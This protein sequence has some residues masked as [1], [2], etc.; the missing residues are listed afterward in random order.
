MRKTIYAVT[1]AAVVFTAAPAHAN[2]K[3]KDGQVACPC[4]AGACGSM[5]WARTWTAPA[6]ACAP[7]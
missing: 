3:A 4:T 6:P 5:R 2:A 7:A 1:A